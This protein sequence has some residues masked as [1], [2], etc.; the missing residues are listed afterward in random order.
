MSM[1]RINIL[2][3]SSDEKLERIY[4]DYKK[5]EMLTGEMKECIT[6]MQGYVKS[7][8]EARAKVTDEIMQAFMRPRKLEWAGNPNPIKPPPSES[9][10]EAAAD[11]TEAKGQKSQGKQA[12]KRAA[13][14]G[15]AGKSE[16]TP[17]AAQ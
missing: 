11:G 8:Q 13:K 12:A 1:W 17:A 5:G 6:L 14:T 10:L 15:K 7:F 4:R 16:E 9:K 3:I 2:R